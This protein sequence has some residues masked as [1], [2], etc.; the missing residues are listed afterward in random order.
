[1]RKRLLIR[2]IIGMSL[3]IG[4]VSFTLTDG[5]TNIP[6]D[7]VLFDPKALLFVISFTVIYSFMVDTSRSIDM[8]SIG[9]GAFYGGVLGFLIG[10]MMIFDT[11]LKEQSV[12]WKYA[13]LPLFYGLLTKVLADALKSASV[14]D[15]QL[16]LF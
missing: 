7:L 2:P 4:M 14:P 11:P 13:V 9:L 16:S 1:M 12:S 5:F 10:V 3:I 15:K 8:H 6:D